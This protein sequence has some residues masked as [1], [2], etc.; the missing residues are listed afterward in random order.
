[1]R[2]QLYRDGTEAD[3]REDESGKEEEAPE[4]GRFMENK[5]AQKYRAYCADARPDGIGGAYGKA[6][7]GFGQQHGAKHVEEGKACHPLPIRQACEALR[8]AKAEGETDLAESC[9]Y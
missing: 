5:D 3:D 4:G 6:F 1:M 8:L 9:Y 2:L 7:C